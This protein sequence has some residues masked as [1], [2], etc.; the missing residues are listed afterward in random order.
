M[1]RKGR[2]TLKKK[3]GKL[4]P[5]KTQK[6]A[7]RRKGIYTKW[8]YSQ[9]PTQQTQDKKRPDAPYGLVYSYALPGNRGVVM[10]PRLEPRKKKTRKKKK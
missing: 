2:A 6:E 7:W 10:T 3:T 1:K 4:S 5:D 9:Q 8:V